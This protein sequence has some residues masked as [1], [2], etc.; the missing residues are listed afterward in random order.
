MDIK[1]TGS[2]TGKEVVQLY[3]GFD[4]VLGAAKEVEFPRSVLR[5]FEKVE[6]ESGERQ[7][8]HFNLTRRDLSYWDVVQQNW[9]M[10]TEGSITIKVGA[11]SR[12]FKLTGWY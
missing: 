11:S 6:L 10:P 1:N 12:D 2:I 8:V 9:V 3:L 5:Q 7:T 4:R